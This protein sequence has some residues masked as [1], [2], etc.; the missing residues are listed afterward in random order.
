MNRAA[1]RKAARFAAAVGLLAATLGTIAPAGPGQALGPIIAI[2]P[3]ELAG[4]S[5]FVYNPS[6]SGRGESAAVYDGE[7]RRNGWALFDSPGV[8]DMIDDSVALGAAVSGNGCVFLRARVE[9]PQPPTTGGSPQIVFYVTDRG[10]GK[11]EDDSR[12]EEIRREML[13]LIEA[14]SVA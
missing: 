2:T 3:N 5:G 9:D 1:F 10:G 11:I 12:L 7:V 6:L 8:E 4:S 14:T 13:A